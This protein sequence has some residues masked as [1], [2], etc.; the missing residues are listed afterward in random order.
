M[1]LS[2]A[3]LPLAGFLSVCFHGLPVLKWI[4]LSQSKQKRST[5]L[6]T[7]FPHSKTV[8]VCGLLT[9]PE[10]FKDFLSVHTER[11]LNSLLCGIQIGHD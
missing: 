6:L 10:L 11:A 2:I 9:C 1:F 8:I 3:V 4:I 7:L 5:G